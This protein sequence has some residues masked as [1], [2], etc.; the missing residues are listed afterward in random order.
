MLETASTMSAPD[1][2]VDAEFAALLC[3]DDELVWAEFDAIVRATWPA[4]RR[5]F[6]PGRRRPRGRR[7]PGPSTPRWR[8]RELNLMRTGRQ[9]PPVLEAG[10]RERSPPRR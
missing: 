4:S 1:T 10:Q 8:Q 5:R 9:G 6:R 2:A 7:A 3:A